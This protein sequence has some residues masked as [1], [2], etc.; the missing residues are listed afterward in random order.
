MKKPNLFIPGFAKC[1][2]S[3]LHTT[4]IQDPY[5]E[6]SSRKEPHTYV[7]NYLY[8]NRYKHFQ[9][10]YSN[11]NESEIKYI[12][13]SSTSYSVSE[14][15]IKRIMKDSPNSKFIL[16]LR[17]PIERI[18]SHYNWLSSLGLVELEFEKEI[19]KYGNLKFRVQDHFYGNYKTYIDAS[20]YGMHLENIS[21][22]VPKQNLKI[23]IFEE[24][25]SNWN[26]IRIE[27]VNF[28]NLPSI[29]ELEMMHENKTKNAI[30]IVRSKKSYTQKIYNQ[31]K[32]FLKLKYKSKKVKNPQYHQIN[33]NETNLSFM[34][35]YLKKD[36]QLLLSLGIDNSK[37][38]TTNKVLLS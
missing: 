15:S 30:K 7:T 29:Q 1:G 6:A 17:D 18:V 27:L 33:V 26:H 3:S 21:K 35:K 23:L 24:L 20:C 32:Y 8:R 36:Y 34:T 14:N 2:T 10:I 19:E 13:D 31:I 9:K 5:I 12:L 4:L 22:I 11:I 37:W 25:I 16:I 28:L 38:Q